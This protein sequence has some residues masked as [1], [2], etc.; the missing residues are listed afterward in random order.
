ML[1]K[2]LK[3]KAKAKLVWDGL[4]LSQ[5]NRGYEVI[6][7]TGNRNLGS[8]QIWNFNAGGPA[9]TSCPD[10]SLIF[11]E[12]MLS[13][14][15]FFLPTRVFNS[16]PSRLSDSA[17]LKLNGI[18]AR[19]RQHQIWTKCIQSFHMPNCN[20]MW[21]YQKMSTLVAVFINF[22]IWTRWISKCEIS[23]LWRIRFMCEEKIM[24]LKRRWGLPTFWGSLET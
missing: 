3:E 8:S 18:D 17:Y 14:G 6:A 10:S 19:I 23:Q 16:L 12:K 11:D 1:G 15:G 4:D 13:I 2:F 21:K 9:P 5:M 22:Q 24:V 20:I 7:Y